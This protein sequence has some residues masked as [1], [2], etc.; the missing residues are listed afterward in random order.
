MFDCI[1]LSIR[2]IYCVFF[3]NHNDI[4]ILS[5][6]IFKYLKRERENKGKYKGSIEENKD[7]RERRRSIFL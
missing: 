5:F 7:E 2:F 3:Q 6:S 4:P 1:L